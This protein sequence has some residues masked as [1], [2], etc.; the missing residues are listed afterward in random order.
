MYKKFTQKGNYQRQMEL[1]FA[2]IKDRVPRLNSVT[3]FLK[4]SFSPLL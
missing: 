3:A 2:T 1:I 4:Y